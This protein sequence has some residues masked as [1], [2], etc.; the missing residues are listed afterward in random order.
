MLEMEFKYD[1][2]DQRYKLLDV[3]PR[4]WTWISLG[5]AAGVDFPH[6]IW[7]LAMGESVEPHRALTGTKWIHLSRDFVAA[8]HEMATGDLALKD[9]LRSLRGSLEFAAFAK[10][11]PLPGLIDLPLVFYRVLTRRLPMMARRVAKANPAA[12]SPTPT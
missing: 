11:D 9:Y 12:R 1:A 5:H 6:I 2:R 10:D 7:R 8:C 3:N 4:T